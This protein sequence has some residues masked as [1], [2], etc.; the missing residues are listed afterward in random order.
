M[1]TSLIKFKNGM[2]GIKVDDFFIDLGNV[3]SHDGYFVLN[4]SPTP[5]MSDHSTVKTIFD[6]MKE[7]GY[8]SVYVGGK[9]MGTVSGEPQSG[10]E[11][12][13]RTIH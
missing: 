10:S 8:G 7:G 2:F 4:V 1:K 12:P 9:P 6:K 11:V 5:S 3:V 13:K